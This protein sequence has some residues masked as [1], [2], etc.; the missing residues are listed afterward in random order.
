VA[1]EEGVNLLPRG[2]FLL[3]L[4]ACAR[5]AVEE[6]PP[7]PANPPPAKKAPAPLPAGFRVTGPA[8]VTEPFLPPDASW[9]FLVSQLTILR[10]EGRDL[11]V[12]FDRSA[13]H[14]TDR[15]GHRRTWRLP[16]GLSLSGVPSHVLLRGDLGIEAGRGPLQAVGDQEVTVVTGRIDTGGNVEEFRLVAQA[17]VGFRS[18]STG[19]AG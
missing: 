15:E 8:E 7:A 11:L 16:K 2:P 9:R 1:P 13:F 12:T 5:N 3:L 18:I 14:A 10:T 17:G 6:P 4:A 19:G